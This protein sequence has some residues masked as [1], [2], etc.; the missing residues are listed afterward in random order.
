MSSDLASEPWQQAT[1][2]RPDI[3][4]L[5]RRP[6]ENHIAYLDG[7]RGIAIMAVLMVHSSMGMGLPSPLRNLTF[8]GVRGVQ[9]FFIVSGLTLLQAHSDRPLDLLNFAARRFFRIAPMF[10]LGAV[11]YL[12]VGAWTAMQSG[13]RNVGSLDILATIL[14]LHGWLPGSIDKVVPGGWSIAAEAMLYL[15]FPAILAVARYPHRLIGLVAAS[16][17]VAGVANILLIRLLPPT[18][19]AKGFAMAFW[20]C[21]V[22][23]FAGG[24][25]LAVVS[26]RFQIDQHAASIA[27]IG[28]TAALLIDSQLRGHSNLLVA[29]LLLT[30]FVWAIGKARPRI[31]EAGFLPYLGRISFSVYI[32]HFVVLDGVR[33]V[34]KVIALP[35]PHAASFLVVYGTTLAVTMAAATLTFRLIEQPAIR[36]GRNLMTRLAFSG[37]SKHQDC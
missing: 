8:Y 17:I 12:A 13:S 9:L 5:S 27:L 24:C 28:S 15:I 6:R 4:Q 11:I 31:V 20:L 16:Y 35:L 37:V 21:Q 1:A 23:A 25:L 26:N 14:F 29:I 34:W 18:P 2:D 10:Y 30:V 19:E 32:L 3:G 33:Y 36:L 22:P 7:L